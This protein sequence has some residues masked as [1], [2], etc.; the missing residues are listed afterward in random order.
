MPTMFTP[1]PSS[2]F[3]REDTVCFAWTGGANP[4]LAFQ[5]TFD[6]NLHTKI[7]EIGLNDDQVEELAHINGD[8]NK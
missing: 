8:N 5:L 1:P 6:N 2:A 3:D 4:Q 7:T